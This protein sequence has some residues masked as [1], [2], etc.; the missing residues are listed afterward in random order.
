LC[1]FCGYVEFPRSV[2]VRCVERATVY[3]P[4]IRG[5]KLPSDLD[6]LPASL[7]ESDPFGM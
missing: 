6:S 2:P 7:A 1:R 4:R 5:F 3:K